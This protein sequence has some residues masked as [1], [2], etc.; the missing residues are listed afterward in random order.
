MK[1]SVGMSYKE[2]ARKGGATSVGLSYNEKQ[3]FGSTTS[4]GMSHKEKQMSPEERKEKAFGSSS[5]D[6]DE[7]GGLSDEEREKL[8]EE[9]EK[10]WKRKK[11]STMCKRISEIDNPLQGELPHS[12]EDL[13]GYPDEPITTEEDGIYHISEK[14]LRKEV[15]RLIT[16]YRRSDS[17]RK[18]W[19][20]EFD[21]ESTRQ[22]FIRDKHTRFQTKPIHDEDFRRLEEN[23]ERVEEIV[24]DYPQAIEDNVPFALEKEFR[25]FVFENFDF[26]TIKGVG[27]VTA[28][29]LQEVA[30]KI[31]GTKWNYGHRKA[32][33]REKTMDPEMRYLVK[34]LKLGTGGF[35]DTR[36]YDLVDQVG[37]K[38]V[39]RLENILDVIDKATQEYVEKQ[40]GTKLDIVDYDGISPEES[41]KFLDGVVSDVLWDTIEIRKRASEDRFDNVRHPESEW[42]LGNVRFIHDVNQEVKSYPQ[43]FVS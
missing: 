1:S 42:N 2:K 33:R 3:A 5:R 40:T 38:T 15:E 22:S 32:P 13:N 10:R 9:R 31:E 26:T 35:R 14:Y 18:R 6:R 28:E 34:Y 12:T 23:P 36:Q 21:A 11:R 16:E 29:S 17:R 37:P 19:K 41:K 4:V 27:S 20:D 24:R 25:K 39:E 8:K 43:S 7:D 30:S